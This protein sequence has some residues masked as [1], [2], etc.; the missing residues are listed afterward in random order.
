MQLKN[1]EIDFIRER[2]KIVLCRKVFWEFCLHMD[3]NFFTRRQKI[4]RPQAEALQ[5]VSEGKIMHLGICDPPR[6]GK[7]Y[8]I[9]LIK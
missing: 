7:S 2:A 8:I 6:T 5:L 1:N 9:S 3:Y 4:L